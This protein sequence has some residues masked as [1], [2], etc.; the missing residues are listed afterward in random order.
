MLGLT[1]LEGFMCLNRQA[2]C[3]LSLHLVLKAVCLNYREM[4]LLQL[5]SLM[6]HLKKKL[7]FSAATAAMIPI[8]AET[9]QG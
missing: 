6:A 5:G 2:R 9:L 4:L 7:H 1:L 8:V 3:T